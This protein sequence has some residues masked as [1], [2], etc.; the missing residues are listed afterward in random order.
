MP[1]EILLDRTGASETSGAL[2]T[3][4]P[5]LHIKLQPHQSLS[6]EGFVTFIGL[7][8]LLMLVPL[9]ILIGTVMWWGIAP[10]VVGALALMWL[11]LKRSW[12]D[13][14]LTEE[15]MLSRDAIKIHRYNPRGPDQSWSANPYWVKLGLHPVP[16][17]NY[18]TLKGSDREVE[19]GRFLSPEERKSLHN[20]LSDALRLTK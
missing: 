8:F 3:S 15:L 16:V 13:G 17:E 5:L 14:T 4:D 18:L 2:S 7:T 20:T 10:F 12:R 1:Y 9:S 19:L 11:M 6:R